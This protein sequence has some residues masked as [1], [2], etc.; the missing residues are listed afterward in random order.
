MFAVNCTINLIRLKFLNLSNCRDGSVWVW[1]FLWI[2][3]ANYVNWPSQIR[4][5]VFPAHNCWTHR[6]P[7]AR[8]WGRWV[9]VWWLYFYNRPSSCPISICNGTD[10]I[11]PA[12]HCALTAP[13]P[14]NQLPSSNTPNTTNFAFCLH[15]SRE[16]CVCVS[17]FARCCAHT[18]TN[19]STVARTPRSR[20][21]I[22]A[23][24]S[25]YLSIWQRNT[26]SILMPST[27]AHNS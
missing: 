8:H 11:P 23:H 27:A 4:C 1:H 13:S 5:S 2:I 12:N 22:G 19:G 17:V 24:T 18:H 7:A 15:L 10:H 26:L 20:S 16:R 6:A 14:A 25:R 21:Q 3:C 9:C